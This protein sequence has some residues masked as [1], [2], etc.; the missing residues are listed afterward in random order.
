MEA[1]SGLDMAI[2]TIE[3]QARRVSNGSLGAWVTLCLLLY[4]SFR[5]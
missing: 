5:G 4:G 3:R 1:R 2:L